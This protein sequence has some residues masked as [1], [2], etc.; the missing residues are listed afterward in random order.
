MSPM[1]RIDAV[2]I[3]SPEQQAD[4]GY[5]QKLSE[6][7]G[8]DADDVRG[9][10]APG[11]S[12]RRVLQ[13]LGASTALAGLSACQPPPDEWLVPRVKRS[14]P[15]E[16]AKQYSTTAS[17]A[18][19]GH[20]I[21]VE[22]R[23]GRPIKVE[24]NP[25]HPATQGACDAISQASVLS[26][27]DP[28]R[29]AGPKQAGKAVSQQALLQELAQ[30]RKNWDLNGGEGLAIVCGAMTSPSEIAALHSIL[31]RWPNARWAVHEPVGRELVHRA[32][33]AVFG[34][35]L[36]P[37]YDFS[38][39]RCVVSLDGDVLQGQPGFV[40]YA[41]DLSARRELDNDNIPVRL[42]A[43][44]STP[45]L[46]GAIADHRLPL[47]PGEIEIA[48]RQ[49]ASTLGLPV[50]APSKKVIPQDWLNS[51]VA[52]LQNAGSGALV[53]AGE[54]QSLATQMLAQLINSLLGATG[55]TVN[56]IS[57]VAAASTQ[58]DLASLRQGISE[59]TLR[60][61]LVLNSNPVFTAAADLNFAEA[62]QSV[63]WCCH[64]GS[65]QDETARA[66]DWHVSAC[67][68]MESWGDLAAYDGSVSLIQ[69]MAM[70][71]HDSWTALQMFAALDGRDH[72]NA[73]TLL[74]QYWRQRFSER[75]APGQNDFDHFWQ[76]SL[77]SGVVAGSAAALQQPSPQPSWQ[78]QLPEEAV[79]NDEL[80]LQW[81]PDPALWD[82]RYANNAWL[83]EM[84]RPITTLCWQNALLIS[85][86]LAKQRGWKEGSVVRVST[87]VGELQLPVMPLP[88]QAN[89]TVTLHLGQGHT[90]LGRV[91]DG[92]GDN[93][94]LLRSHR[95]PWL[96][97]VQ[98][99]ATGKS[100]KLALMQ[101]HHDIEGRDLIRA[102]TLAQYR[103][104]PHFAQHAGEEDMPSLYPEPE[105]LELQGSDG[106]A[107]AMTIDLSA[108]IGC[109]A[110]VTA[111]QA[112][113]NIPVVG[114][115]EV[116]RGHDMHWIRIDRYFSGP[117]DTPA[118]VFQPVPCMHCENAPCE[119]VCPVGATQHSSEGLNQMVYQR[120]IGTRYCSQ[121]CPYKVRRF[122]WFDYNAVDASYPPAPA[123][124]NPEVTVRSRGVME[125]CSYCVQRIQ[126]AGQ[127]ADAEGRPLQDGEIQTACQQ[128][129]PTQAI[130]FGD[131]NQ[132]D[133]AVSRKKASPR[134]YDM[135][136]HLNVRPRT[137]YLAAVRNPDPRLAA[138]DEEG[139]S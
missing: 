101:Q 23:G 122:N 100:Q 135:L 67:H 136:G 29:S 84:P 125:K 28:D 17:V 91:A 121:N 94:Y 108:C 114:Q 83:Q 40:R 102:A 74:Q 130:V 33:A 75:N 46:F 4:Y 126:N 12:R 59:G 109:N 26:F 35:V 129:C 32:S 44:E 95:Q 54:Q 5:W 127:Q 45:G 110:C 60:E 107:W 49:L 13:L 119:Y 113:N 2:Q 92:C 124:Q 81:R 48:A 51:V 37:V 20:G 31:Q 128:A 30:R 68:P 97:P 72:R 56:Y 7:G 14:S 112:E 137:S 118:M 38:K 1:K 80:V 98:L 64:F 132:A 106:P 86:S 71:L 76:Q 21:V 77:I 57:P 66:S 50:A 133:S 103:A 6:L 134:N 15:G 79:S 55:S 93:A 24:G 42:Y 88:G 36:E 116:A 10:A 47:N 70:P 61:M 138:S 117:P 139:G 3:H 58:D 90:G 78:Q 82:G 9:V 62:Y 115:E 87:A 104:D 41:K 11:L 16:T 89:N 19:Y 96:L 39:V 63:N 18:G 43:L 73:L 52:A 69:P 22:T 34:E 120:C 111:C 65:Y 131:R 105:P 8:S 99:R 123:R 53:L 27:Y 85:P 25:E